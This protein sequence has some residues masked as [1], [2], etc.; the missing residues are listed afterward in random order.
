MGRCFSARW[1]KPKILY[2]SYAK[3]WIYMF[4]F[5]YKKFYAN[6]FMMIRNITNIIHLPYR[7]IH[8]VMSPG[9]PPKCRLFCKFFYNLHREVHIFVS[10]ASLTFSLFA[11]V[12]KWFLCTS[13]L[14]SSVNI[15]KMVLEMR[16][17]SIWKVLN[18]VFGERI[19]WEF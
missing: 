14:I 7:D 19:K 17:A 1:L 11:K 5:Q 16:R 4:Y 6:N 10:W 8:Q 12:S 2:G 18:D 13:L 15:N 9:S 3:S